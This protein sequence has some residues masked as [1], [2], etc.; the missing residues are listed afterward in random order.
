M[1]RSLFAALVEEMK[2]EKTLRVRWD[3]AWGYALSGPAPKAERGQ[4]SLILGVSQRLAAK[5]VFRFWTMAWEVSQRPFAFFSAFI[6]TSVGVDRSLGF[7]LARSKRWRIDRTDVPWPLL[8]C[9]PRSFWM[10]GWFL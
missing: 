3:T 9:G 1:K 10:I 8:L 5:S 2:A 7:S 6:S 4:K